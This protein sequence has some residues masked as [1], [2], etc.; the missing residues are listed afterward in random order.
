MIYI[1][2]KRIDLQIHPSYLVN[3][4]SYIIKQL[5]LLKNTCNKEDGYVLDIDLDSIRYPNKS[6]IS[7]ISGH[8]IIPI[9]IV[10]TYLKPVIGAI[11]I[12]EI[13]HVYK[14]GIVCTYKTI[15][16][17][18]PLIKI[19]NIDELV[20]GQHLKVKITSIEYQNHR[21]NCIGEVI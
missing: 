20:I 1:K 6:L 19:K 17:F 5:E 8:V 11:D 18:I 16:C 12:W 21:Y 14:E 13:S 2:E 10:F 4:K 9:E 3:I 15:N 7:R